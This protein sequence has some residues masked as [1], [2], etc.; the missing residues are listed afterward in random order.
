MVSF[1]FPAISS[2]ISM[3][4]WRGKTD[5]SNRSYDI[6][7]RKIF[8]R[9][10]MRQSET[11]TK[12]VRLLK[13]HCPVHD[14]ISKKKAEMNMYAKHR[15]RFTQIISL[16]H[17]V[18]KDNVVPLA[19]SNKHLEGILINRHLK[20]TLSNIYVVENLENKLKYYQFDTNDFKNWNCS[21]S[22]QWWKFQHPNGWLKFI[23]QYPTILD[24]EVSNNSAS[25]NSM[26]R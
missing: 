24:H 8:I 7:L 25:Q 12:Y 13:S 11:W 1:G 26:S 14:R 16:P 5:K 22:L 3:A 23:W 21:T 17:S 20:Q 15:T 19:L 10:W 9:E 4:T 18:D 2:F 6:N